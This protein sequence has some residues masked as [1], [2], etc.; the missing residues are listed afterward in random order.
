MKINVII[1]NLF[2]VWDRI[3]TLYKLVMSDILYCL[4]I[5]VFKSLFFPSKYIIL[6]L[7]NSLVLHLFRKRLG[8]CMNLF[9]L[10]YRGGGSA[11]YTNLEIFKFET[12]LE[13]Q[14]I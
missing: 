13:T 2:N 14:R 10:R 1:V 9:N 3:V 6:F 8:A 4:N 7:S 12:G 5:Y 11:V